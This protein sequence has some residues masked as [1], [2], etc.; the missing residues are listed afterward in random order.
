MKSKQTEEK[1]RISNIEINNQELKDLLYKV[2]NQKK[3]LNKDEDLTGVYTREY[4]DQCI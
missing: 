2:N 4:I 1:F 3:T